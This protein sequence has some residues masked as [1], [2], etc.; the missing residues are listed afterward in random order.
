[1]QTR[2]HKDDDGE[3]PMPS[4]LTGKVLKVPGLLGFLKEKYEGRWSDL[5]QVLL[6]ADRLGADMLA[7]S[8]FFMN[9]TGLLTRMGS[10]QVPDYVLRALENQLRDLLLEEGVDTLPQLLVKRL[11]QLKGL[12]TAH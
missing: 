5:V 6:D 10:D 8:P 3:W 11:A 7:K 4:D 1:M 12:P 9:E 2:G